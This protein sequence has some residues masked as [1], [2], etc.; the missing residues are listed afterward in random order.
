VAQDGFCQRQHVIYGR[1]VTA[2]EQRARSCGKHQRLAGAGSRSPG[3]TF[4][5]LRQSAFLR[6]SRPDEIEYRLHDTVADGNLAHQF[7]G[8]CQI[9]GAQHLFRRGFFY[10]GGC[11]KHFALG[12]L[13][14]VAH[15]DLQQEPVQLCF[16]QRVGAFLFQRV[17]RCQ[18]M[19]RVR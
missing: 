2:V 13:R 17:L 9:L 11:Q 15:I 16:G 12:F 4:A 10:A 18:H 1:R 7:L 14:R 8:G 6:P 5:D 19:K 3:Y